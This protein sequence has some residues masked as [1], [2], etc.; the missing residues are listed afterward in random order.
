[1]DK[2]YMKITNSKNSKK[3]LVDAQNDFDS[4]RKIGDG[5][6]FTNFFS[7]FKNDEMDTFEYNHRLLQSIC[8][9][10]FL[11]GHQARRKF[12]LLI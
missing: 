5:N 8:R 12:V 9:M 4:I 10:S 3:F 1:M 6:I 2:F 7:L 11:S